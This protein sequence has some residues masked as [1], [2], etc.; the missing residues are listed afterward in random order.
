VLAV[1]TARAGKD[2]RLPP[3]QAV[4]HHIGKAADQRTEHTE[5]KWHE[6]HYSDLGAGVVGSSHYR[7][8]EP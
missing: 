1:R 6:G 2:D 5:E 8:A 4:D 3:R 7:S